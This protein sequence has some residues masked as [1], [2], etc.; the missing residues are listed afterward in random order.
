MH[1]LEQG[2]TA[3]SEIECHGDKPRKR[4]Q[5]SPSALYVEALFQ[6]CRGQIATM[7]TVCHVSAVHIVFL[8]LKCLYLLSLQNT[9]SLITW[10]VHEL[11]V[12]QSSQKMVR[13]KIDSRI[14]VMIENGVATRHRSLFVIVGDQGKDQ[15]SCK[16][17]L[18]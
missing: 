17:F 16:R 2:C 3:E 12:T 14:R 11:G 4:N 9:P 10:A 5:L 7:L 1:H 13:K 15:A 18:K 6:H 8:L